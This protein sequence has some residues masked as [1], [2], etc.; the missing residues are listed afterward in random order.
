MKKELVK[1]VGLEVFTSKKGALCMTIH[2]LAP[3]NKRETHTVCTGNKAVSFF[4]SDDLKEKISADDV[5][6]EI[7]ICTLFFGGKNNL[8]DIDK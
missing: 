6:K 8:L 1:L 2:V 4:V 3:L 5:G 7:T